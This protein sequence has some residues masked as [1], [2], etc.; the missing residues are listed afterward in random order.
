MDIREQ[1]VERKLLQL[2]FHCLVPDLFVVSVPSSESCV[3]VSPVWLTFAYQTMM[4]E[5]IKNQLE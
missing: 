4:K 5:E 3:R 1:K 2:D